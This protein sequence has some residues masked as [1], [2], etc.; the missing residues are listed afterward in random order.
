MYVTID[1]TE[2]KQME[3]AL[4]KSQRLA[5]IGE[6]AAMVGHDL[7]NP[8]TGI[9]G[10]AYYLKKKDGSRL[11]GG[12]KEMLQLIQ[13]DI[14]RSDKIINDLVEYS[15]EPH[16][17]PSHTNLRSITEDALAEV[18]FQKGIRVVNSTKKQ[19]AM[20]LDTDRMRRVFVNIIQ[21][22]VDAMPKGGTLT[23]ASTRSGDNVRITFRDTGEGMT[24]ENLTRIWS[25]LFTTKAKGI[26]L[27]L[28]IAKRFV[29]AH[30]GS[31]SVETKLGKGSTFTVT[32]PL[33]QGEVRSKR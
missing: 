2:R 1:T 23:I 18:K 12:G 29:E 24:P 27:G 7:R 28:A 19:P 9:T 22:A 26:G 16:L 20:M 30:G 33:R 8:L 14:R 4:L 32:I 3:E 6:L 10:A 17:E 11:S 31:I 5:T 15:K 13:E 21:N 25:P